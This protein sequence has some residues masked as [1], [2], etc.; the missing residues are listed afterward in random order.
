MDGSKYEMKNGE[1]KEKR[2]KMKKFN[3]EI[4][5]KIYIVKSKACV[6]YIF[7]E[8]QH[9]TSRIYVWLEKFEINQ[10]INLKIKST[11]N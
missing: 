3:L 7:D 10:R 11:C 2:R 8:K 6:V 5:R 9:S 1:R 4:L